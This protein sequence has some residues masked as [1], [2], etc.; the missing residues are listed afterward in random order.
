[1][2]TLIVILTGALM[3]AG[4]LGTL[5]PFLPGCPLIF[6]GAFLYAWHTGFALVSWATLLLLLT[7]AVLSEVLDKI[8]TL[9][10]AKR[11]GASRWGLIGVLIGGVGGLILAGPLGLALGAFLGAAALE[12]LQGRALEGAFRAG[13]GALIGMA[14]GAL[15]KLVI[16]LIMIGIFLYRVGR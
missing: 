7:L 1:M 5:L 9:A 10:G 11:Y 3:L 8:A 14:G 2:Q 12:F 15:G 6:G 4:L 13:F 16:G